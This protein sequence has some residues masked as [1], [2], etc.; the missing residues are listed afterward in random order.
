MSASAARSVAGTPKICFY[1][2]NEIA[3]I[4]AAHH[5]LALGQRLHTTQGFAQ[6][7]MAS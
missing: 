7:F 5:P 4:I 1:A 6:Q 3:S 2:G